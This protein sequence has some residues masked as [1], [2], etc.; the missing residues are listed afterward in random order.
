MGHRSFA[1]IVAAADGDDAVTEAIY[2]RDPQ[3]L[4]RGREWGRTLARRQ[5]LF[6]ALLDID[7]GYSPNLRPLR[8]AI[9][10][11]ANAIS[12]TAKRIWKVA[13]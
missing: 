7:D 3:A 2:A 12:W 5:A 9:A 4:M 8:P 13:P 1:Q 10:V 11:A 6:M